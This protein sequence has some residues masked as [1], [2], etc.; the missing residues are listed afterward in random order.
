MQ[1][2]FQQTLKSIKARAGRGESQE[3]F[4]FGTGAV[5]VPKNIER[6]A[7]NTNFN[8]NNLSSKIFNVPKFNVP[9]FN[10]PKFNVPKF[11]NQFANNLQ[12]KWVKLAFILKEFK[13]SK[14]TNH[15]LIEPLNS[16]I[17]GVFGHT[18]SMRDFGEISVF[19]SR[20]TAE[21]DP[22]DNESLQREIYFIDKILSQPK[23][24]LKHPIFGYINGTATSIE[25]NRNTI[26]SCIITFNFKE[27]QADLDEV[28]PQTP[29]ILKK[30]SFFSKIKN[31]IGTIKDYTFATISE[32]NSVV[33]KIDKLS[34]SLHNTSQTLNALQS[35]V[36]G[37]LEPFNRL[38]HSIGT[39]TT[40]GR[41]LLRF[42]DKLG[43][44]LEQ[45]GNNFSNINLSLTPSRPNSRESIKKNNLYRQVVKSLLNAD[46]FALDNSDLLS[47]ANEESK[48]SYEAL[49]V[50]QQSYV[51]GLALFITDDIDFNTTQEIDEIKKTIG[52][53]A[54]ALTGF[55]LYLGTD[56]YG[57]QV[58]HRI[59]F[60]TEEIIELTLEI[61]SLYSDF[62]LRMQQLKQVLN[63][64]RS[65]VI[66]EPINMINLVRIL[67]NGEYNAQNAEEEQELINQICYLNK[68][69]N[70]WF[71]S[72]KIFY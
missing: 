4:K 69:D 30:T 24:R 18:P 6:P 45:I 31:T 3:N 56:V 59:E 41:D 7:V 55:Q 67:Y 65:T 1:N 8:V 44:K 34:G 27:I 10:V 29:S 37:T 11:D 50:S 2:I 20:Q 22:I 68:I 26:N 14:L 38:A 71:I 64:R 33:S 35:N 39:L 58:Y 66:K 15:Q 32:F 19:I 16:E 40:S 54:S 46:K 17:R 60:L 53:V 63:G 57:N 42:P 43:N 51:L 70:F 5:L 48:A 25:I 72:G 36:L 12:R 23:V 13:H 52:T 49:A 28:I 47:T 9:K 62:L 61:S 21:N